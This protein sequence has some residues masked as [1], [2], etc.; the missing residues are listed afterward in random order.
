MGKI[1]AFILAVFFILGFCP[2]FAQNSDNVPYLSAEDIAAIEMVLPDDY[3]VSRPEPKAPPVQEI[4][5]EITRLNATQPVYHLLILDRA[6]SPLDSDISDLGSIRVLY[7]Y[8]H[9]RNGYLIALYVSTVNGPIF[10]QLPRN[11]RVVLDMVTVTKNT[12]KDYINSTAFRKY[13]TNRTVQ[14]ALLNAL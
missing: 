11:S 8:K 13:V 7:K 9:G 6:R 3:P 2:V 14:T 10:P 12:I 4:K 5:N 1:N